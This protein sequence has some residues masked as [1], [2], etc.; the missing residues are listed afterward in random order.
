MRVPRGLKQRG[1]VIA[2]AATGRRLTAT[3]NSDTFAVM[4][5]ERV[6]YQVRG[7]LAE[8]KIA[9]ERYTTGGAYRFRVGSAVVEI[10]F[11][12]WDDGQTIVSLQADVLVNLDLNEDALR[13]AYEHINA[14]NHMTKF[15]KF[16]ID[17]DR[18]AIVLEHDLLGDELDA[19]EL[20]NA[21]RTVGK[22]ADESDDLLRGRL[23]TGD[24]AG[25]VEGLAAGAGR[26]PHGWLT[27]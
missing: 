9:V 7:I 25:D 26:R 27:S 6:V 2:S 11:Y 5:K 20:L 21:L 10:D 14:L 22:H 13:S 19:S 17:V 15:G 16:Y 4:P 8:E 24:R 3:T 12:D 18:H 23:G 1:A